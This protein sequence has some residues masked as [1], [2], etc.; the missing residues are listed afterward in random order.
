M[1]VLPMLKWLS[2]SLKA[3]LF[4]FCGMASSISI[5]LLPIRNS[6][7]SIIVVKW[8]YEILIYSSRDTRAHWG[9]CS[10]KHKFGFNTALPSYL[11]HEAVPYLM[12]WL[13]S[14]TVRPGKHVY[15]NTDLSHGYLGLKPTTLFTRWLLPY[16][17]PENRGSLYFVFILILIII[18][19]MVQF[20]SSLNYVDICSFVHCFFY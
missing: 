18:H 12:P 7:N 17:C 14:H 8:S 9:N 10:F 16:K 3:A 11:M 5:F 6:C 4:I 1:H 13:H 15:A 20:A 2:I 19:R